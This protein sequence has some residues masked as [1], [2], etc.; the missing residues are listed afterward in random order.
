LINS[1]FFANNK[2]KLKFWFLF[3]I[4]L[5]FVSTFSQVLL[6]I[7]FYLIILIVISKIITISER[8]L[9]I[10]YILK[11][12]FY[13]APFEMVCRMVQTSPFIPYE[14]GKY[15]TCAL[16]IIGISQ[17]YKGKSLGWLI[18]LFL[19][20]GIIIGLNSGAKFHNIVFNVFGL[21][22]FSLGI[23][24]FGGLYLSKHKINI[25]EIVRL[26]VYALIVA[27][28]YAFIL[29]PKYDDV[30]F[31]LTA[32]FETTGGFG[33]NQVSTAFGLALFL[34][35]YLW[36][37]GNSFTGFSTKLDLVLALFFLFQGLLTFSRGGIIGGIL[38][39]VL[40]FLSV[41]VSR[42]RISVHQQII[43]AKRIILYSVPLFF[44]LILGAN[45]LTKGQLLLRYQGE[46]AGT[47]AGTKEKDINSLTTGRFDIFIGD[48]KLFEEN[49]IFGVGVDQSRYFRNTH[50]GVVAHVEFSRLLAEHGLM[51]L[52]I[53]CFLFS[54]IFSKLYLLKT[55][56]S[57]LYIL[58]VIGFYTTFHAATRTF[59]SPLTMAII[60]IPTISL[61]F[62]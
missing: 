37:T 15:I 25:K 36:F 7:W 59:I 39:I 8:E 11:L 10:I 24:F 40:L 21:I 17:I 9:K 27:L 28:I 6:I 2:D 55:E 3:H 57:I 29:A 41:L 19:V 18:F 23:V 16:L 20:P 43:K 56:H 31:D 54:I 5:G 26:M 30:N 48:V 52:V 44:V 58:F 35:F 53:G 45:L 60:F 47:L 62:K 38:G 22:D 33:S 49:S 32:N 13:L 51:G 50:E 14:I 46:S 12:L 1:L 4:I 34:L 61:K 42:L